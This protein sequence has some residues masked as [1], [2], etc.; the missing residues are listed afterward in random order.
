MSFS[1]GPGKIVI[2]DKEYTGTSVVYNQEGIKIDGKLITAADGHPYHAVAIHVHGDV[3]QVTT[4]SA[5]VKVHGDVLRNVHSTLGSVWVEGNIDGDASST[6]G[7]IHAKSIRGQASTVSGS[8]DRDFRS[9]R[10]AKK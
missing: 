2:G 8:I 10:S 3:E 5:K 1:G 4:T 6:S 7:S 9:A